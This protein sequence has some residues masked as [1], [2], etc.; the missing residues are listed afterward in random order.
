LRLRSVVSS[1]FV[2]WPMACLVLQQG[3]I[4]RRR[5]S[6]TR[7]DEIYIPS[8]YDLKLLKCSRT[9]STVSNSAS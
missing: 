1:A 7:T 3:I 4:D 6:T 9:D 5:R 2:A 8:P